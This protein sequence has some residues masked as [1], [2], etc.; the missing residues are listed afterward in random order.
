M[1]P[2]RVVEGEGSLF[3]CLDDLVGRLISFVVALLDN[4]DSS[5]VNFNSR[6]TIFRRLLGKKQ[7]SSLS[8]EIISSR[9]GN[10]PYIMS[11]DCCK[12]SFS[13]HAAKL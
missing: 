9:V 6:L 7:F 3:F 5:T 11:D 4:S 8:F 1:L 12:A 13:K 2:L 10:P